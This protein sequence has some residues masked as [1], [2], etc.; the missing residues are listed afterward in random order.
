MLNI[1]YDYQSL[2]ISRSYLH[3]EKLNR[4]VALELEVIEKTFSKVEFSDC[5]WLNSHFRGSRFLSCQF[6]Q[7]VMNYSQFTHCYFEDS[8]FDQWLIR[9][10]IFLNC[11]FVNCQFKSTDVNS[12]MIERVSFPNSYLK[13]CHLGNLP[14]L[15]EK[16]GF[17][18][19]FEATLISNT[20]LEGPMVELCHILAHSPSSPPKETSS[21]SPSPSSSMASPKVSAA[22]PA[23]K[24]PKSRFGQ[25]EINS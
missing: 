13:D 23:P 3:E 24:E 11:V 17:L 21:L 20:P 9:N 22:A 1:E 14:L 4:W 18:Q 7:S 10:T 15:L 25:L 2:I 6:L 12:D 16:K 19:A 8:V 5:N